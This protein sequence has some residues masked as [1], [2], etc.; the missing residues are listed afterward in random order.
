MHAILV[1]EFMMITKSVKLLERT[2][3]IRVCAQI[4]VEKNAYVCTVWY[5]L[6]CL[7]LKNCL[8]WKTEVLK[9]SNL[10]YVNETTNMSTWWVFQLI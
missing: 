7:F 1:I 5:H 10:L 2:F 4:N 6:F 3:Q 9:H 8:F